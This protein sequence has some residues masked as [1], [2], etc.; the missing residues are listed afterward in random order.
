[1][2]LFSSISFYIMAQ[3]VQLTFE[4]WL[5]RNWSWMVALLKLP[6]LT[7]DCLNFRTKRRRRKKNKLAQQ[8][9][10]NLAGLTSRRLSRLDFD[11]NILLYMIFSSHC[12]KKGVIEREEQSGWNTWFGR[13]QLKLI[14]LTSIQLFYKYSLCTSCVTSGGHIFRVLFICRHLF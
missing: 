12:C 3:A 6:Q 2:S 14:P 7:L 5:H 11:H 4:H 13:I 10:F 1:M 9:V 8:R